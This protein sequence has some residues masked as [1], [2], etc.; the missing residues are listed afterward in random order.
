MMSV[1]RIVV[2][3]LICYIHIIIFTQGLCVVLELHQHSAA[4]K[5]TREIQQ[6]G[7]IEQHDKL[8]EFSGHDD[9]L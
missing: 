8:L 9:G 1:G 2:V 3:I 7:V 5:L 6:V 4:E